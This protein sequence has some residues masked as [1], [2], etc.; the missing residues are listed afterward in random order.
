LHAELDRLNDDLKEGGRRL[1]E[2][3][4]SLGVSPLATIGSAAGRRPPNLWPGP[5]TDEE[6][7]RIIGRHLDLL[8]QLV[9][10][11][12]AE[13]GNEASRSALAEVQ[14]ELATHRQA[15]A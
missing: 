2:Q 15:L 9:A 10:R 12:M 11:A 3:D 8:A 5:A 14:R 13:Q 4:E 6:V 7:R 1:I